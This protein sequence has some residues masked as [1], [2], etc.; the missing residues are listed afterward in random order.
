MTQLKEP[1][2]DKLKEITQLADKLFDEGN[3]DLDK[4]DELEAEA[5]AEKVAGD[6]GDWRESFVQYRELLKP[7]DL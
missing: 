5:E 2:W 6:F 4:L 3:L 7:L 1:D